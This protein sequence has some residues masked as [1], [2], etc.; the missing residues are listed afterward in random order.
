MSGGAT[1]RGRGT[2]PGEVQNLDAGC[3]GNLGC[4]RVVCR[5]DEP[6]LTVGQVAA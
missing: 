6:R 2:E 3:L 1:H 4:E 5:D